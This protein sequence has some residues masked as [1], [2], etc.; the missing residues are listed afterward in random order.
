MPEQK[1]ENKIFM[2][3]ILV[4]LVPM[5]VSLAIMQRRKDKQD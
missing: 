5:H 4:A 2:F 3:P 1:I